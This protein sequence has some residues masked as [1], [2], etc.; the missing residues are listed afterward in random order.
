M[1]ISPRHSLKSHKSMANKKEDSQR[2]PCPFYKHRIGKEIYKRS[3]LRNKLGKIHLMK[4]N[5]RLRLKAIN[6]S[7][8]GEST[9]KL[10]FKM[11]PRKVL[12]QKSRSGNSLDHF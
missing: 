12:L 5:F 1:L 2:E 9:L 7:H 11:L 10:S 3:R 8:F 4:T 6:I